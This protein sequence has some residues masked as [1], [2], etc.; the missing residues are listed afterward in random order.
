MRDK[1]VA[2]RAYYGVRSRP[3]AAF[4]RTVTML[5]RGPPKETFVHHAAFFFDSNVSLRTLLPFSSPNHKALL[6]HYE[7]MS[8]YLAGNLTLLSNTAVWTHKR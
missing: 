4:R 7:D 2:Q 1:V 6:G 5:Q 8:L 3:F